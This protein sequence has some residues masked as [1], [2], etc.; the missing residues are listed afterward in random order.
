MLSSKF[1]RTVFAPLL[2]C[3]YTWELSLLLAHEDLPDLKVLVA[4]ADANTE[5][6]AMVGGVGR[7][8]GGHGCGS[9]RTGCSRGASRQREVRGVSRL[10]V[11]LPSRP[12]RRPVFAKP[13]GGTASRPRPKSNLVHMFLAEKRIGQGQLNNHRERPPPTSAR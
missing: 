1:F 5:V 4:R 3:F 12:E 10:K 7:S 6:K 13:T 2:G 9:G 11:V 8:A